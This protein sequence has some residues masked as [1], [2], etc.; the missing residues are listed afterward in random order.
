ML[1]I[2]PGPEVGRSQKVG[3]TDCDVLRRLT[4]PHVLE[5]AH[6]RC[7]VDEDCI[8]VLSVVRSTLRREFDTRQERQKLRSV[9]A[10]PVCGVR[11]QVP[12]RRRGLRH[13]DGIEGFQIGGIRQPF[14]QQLLVR[15]TAL[16]QHVDLPVAQLRSQFRSLEHLD[17]D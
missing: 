13:D 5:C 11:Q 12:E 10:G 14:R 6:I 16:Y 3:M 1:L 7:P 2:S 17:G 8:E 9:L 15:C 4:A